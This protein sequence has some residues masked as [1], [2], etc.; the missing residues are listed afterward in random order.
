[1]ENKEETKIISLPQNNFSK[2]DD[3]FCEEWKQKQEA[4]F[5]M[6]KNYNE[7]EALKNIEENLYL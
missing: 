2:K 5:T 7:K 1:M 3:L 4:Y 6:E